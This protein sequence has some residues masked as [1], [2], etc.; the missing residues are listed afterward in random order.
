MLAR[1]ESSNRMSNRVGKSDESWLVEVSPILVDDS[2]NDGPSGIEWVM[3]GG[4]KLKHE[5]Q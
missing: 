4:V 2:L 1:S 3:R 5:A